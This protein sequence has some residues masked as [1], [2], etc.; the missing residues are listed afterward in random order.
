[1]TPHVVVRTAAR[2]LALGL[3]LSGCGLL[4]D[5]LNIR[6]LEPPAVFAAWYA[7]LEACAGVRGDFAGLSWMVTDDYVD[8]DGGFYWRGEK[9]YGLYFAKDHSILLSTAS[10]KSRGIVKHEE[11]HSLLPAAAESDPTFRRCGALA[12]M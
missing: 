11:L 3:V 8:A 12:G 1:M 10:A 9:V 7:E 6:R 5:P 4:T 2:S